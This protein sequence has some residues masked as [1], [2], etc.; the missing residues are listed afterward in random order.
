MGEIIVK[1]ADSWLNLPTHEK[2][3]TG[4]KD[5][6]THTMTATGWQGELTSQS[7]L[8]FRATGQSL[9]DWR[10]DGKT[11]ENLFDGTLIPT[12]TMGVTFRLDNDGYM[13]ANPTNSDTRGWTY[14]YSQIKLTLPSG[15]YCLCLSGT[16]STNVGSGIRVN[17]DADKNLGNKGAVNGQSTIIINFAVTDNHNIGIVAKIHDGRFHVQILKGTYTTQTVPPYE[18]YGGVG[19]WDETEQQYKIPITVNDTTT[20]IYTDHQLI[21][22]D[23][24]DYT[25]DQT[26][27]PITQGDNTLTVGTAVQPSK[28]FVKFE[29]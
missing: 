20:N 17:D 6:P 15:N 11:S 12:T 5:I 27:I 28:V 4:W 2:T 21:D 16:P 24:L 13:Y 22:G 18:P 1:T 25:T 23:S 8:E 9:L 26:S 14:A 3:S 19:D 10:V 7:P 29:G